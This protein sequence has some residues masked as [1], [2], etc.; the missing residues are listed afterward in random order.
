[1]NIQQSRPAAAAPVASGR[2][3]ERP[4]EALDYGLYAVT[5]VAWSLSWFAIEF[6]VGRV[7]NE[8]TIVGQHI[9]TNQ[10]VW[11]LSA[12]PWTNAARDM[13]N[14]LEKYCRA[15]YTEL[16]DAQRRGVKVGASR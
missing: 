10:P 8:V 7:A 11:K 16:A 1:M 6:Q 4:F 3:S 9:V 2:P 13:A 14:R 15:L 5:V 12:G